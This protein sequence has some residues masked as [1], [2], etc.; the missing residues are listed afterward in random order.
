MKERGGRRSLWEAGNTAAA[1][2]G[3]SKGKTARFGVVNHVLSRPS[4]RSGRAGTA[5]DTLDFRARGRLAG[6]QLAVGV[7]PLRPKLMERHAEKLGDRPIGAKVRA[8]E[9]PIHG[10]PAEPDGASDLGEIRSAL[11]HGSQYVRAMPTLFDDP[12]HEALTPAREA[13]NFWRPKST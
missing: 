11:P 7:E 1:Q 9:R 13:P 2:S 6:D 3:G 5:R 10:L 12:I 8:D 4:A